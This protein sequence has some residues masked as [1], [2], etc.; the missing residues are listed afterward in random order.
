MLKSA[1]MVKCRIL[2]PKSQ[3]SLV[4]NTLYDAKLYH[5]TPHKKNENN[6][7]IGVPLANAESYSNALVKIRSVLSQFPVGIKKNLPEL[8]QKNWPVYEKGI[9]KLY[10]DFIEIQEKNKQ[11]RAEE[12]TVHNAQETLKIFQKFQVDLA[13]LN[14]SRYLTY[15]F[16][17]VEK[18][19]NLE[20]SFPDSSL[21]AIDKHILLVGQKEN[22]ESLATGLQLFGFQEIPLNYQK[23]LNTEITHNRQ[24]LN[25]VKEQLNSLEKQMAKIE[26]DLPMLRALEEKVSEEI[27]KEE[28]PLSFAVTSS[29]FVAEGFLPQEDSEKLKRLLENNTKNKIHVEISQPT[30]NDK[31]PIKLNHKKLVT[32]FEF[33]IRLFDLPKYKEIDPTSLV[34]LT[35][36]LFFGFMLGD[37][38]YGLVLLLG[39]W[40][41]KKK[42]PAAKQLASILMFA[43]LISIIFG[44]VFGEYFGFEHVSL[45]TGK[46]W[47]DN[48][49]ICLNPHEV[50]SHGVTSMVADFPRLLNR[51]HGMMHVFGFDILSVLVIGA[52]VGFI[53]VNLGLLFGFVNELES[54]GFKHA[55]MA[56]FSWIMLEIGLILIVLKVMGI[57]GSLMLWLGLVIIALS[58]YLLGKGEGIQGLIEI[59]ALFSNMLS[60][61]RLGAVGLASVGL[62]V[63]VNENLGMPFIEKGGF[64][65]V[66]GILIMIIG[67][68]INILLGIIGPFLHGIRL[69]YVEF[70]GKFF[71]GGGKEYKPFGDKEE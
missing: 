52:I 14:H 63:V 60:Y 7:D 28:L 15:F 50:E 59:P 46:A 9:N 12:S 66:I 31:P 1:R 3:A 21:T 39:F 5:L 44:F 54:H 13:G 36:P 17:T 34:F 37:V 48:L 20:T 71:H 47:C 41:L 42:V 53:H 69:H 51:A 40:L 33:L 61:M 22:R 11:L 35:F 58:L 4:I 19:D 62:A 25:K 55:F 32:P 38:G 64:F 16:G 43:A 56:K 10:T 27:K 23:D 30:K 65:I 18:K 26:K 70:F 29:S 57:F 8:D 24:Q 68:G 6:L 67:H 45:E 2:A 49:G